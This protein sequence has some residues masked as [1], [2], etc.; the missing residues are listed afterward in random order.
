MPSRAVNPAFCPGF[1]GFLKPDGSGSVSPRTM[2]PQVLAIT[3]ILLTLPAVRAARAGV[4]HTC[5]QGDA[6][7]AVDGMLDDWAGVAK[8]RAGGTAADASFDV[9]CLYDD[10]R[11]AL[12][13]DVRDDKLIR[14]KK[15]PATEDAIELSL[16]AGGTPVVLSV[17]PGALGAKPRRTLDGKAVPKWLA[18]EDTLQDKGFSVELVVPLAKL[19]GYASGT[20]ALTAR[21]T[22][23]D[24]DQATAK[25]TDDVGIE[26]AL[27][28]AAKV[29]LLRDFLRAIKAKPGDVKLDQQADVDPDR[30][31]A[32]RVVVA[33]TALG[34]LA[35]Q[36]AYVT[37]PVQA[38]ADV[39]D[40]KL[41]ALGT[42]ATKLVAATV[43]QRGNGGSRDV[44]S[45]FT[46]AGG[47]P[48][49]LVSIE[50][51]KQIG[52]RQLASTWKVATTKVKGKPR[53]ELV[54]VAGPATG[55]DADTWVEEPAADLE[56]I[57]LPWDEDR[58]GTAFW[59]DRG[60]VQRRIIAPPKKSR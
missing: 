50:I 8:V 22:F 31:G 41:I 3:A 32:E 33:G 34:V 2:R 57:N 44:L 18:V 55:F 53:A 26:L 13:F 16:A 19:P 10:K 4:T 20:P 36:F 9:Y 37:L 54:V 27:G 47:Q 29:D 45:V 5:V 1:F 23:H 51:K 39:L 60:S 21:A 59:L 56:P 30:A 11:V 43:R 42:G 24:A 38:A 6:D 46:V 40:V 48:S 7:V 49:P 35:E 14:V 25:E 52:D 17:M 12:A 28:L 58:Y 15:G